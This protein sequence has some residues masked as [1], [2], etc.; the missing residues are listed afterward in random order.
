MR[1]K[2][3]GLALALVGA[4]VATA[5]TVSAEGAT[6][7]GQE[8]TIIVED[9][10]LLTV[11]TDG[12]DVIVG[13]LGP[14]AIDAGAGNDIICGHSGDD[15]LIGGAGND[16]IEGGNDDDDIQGGDGDDTLFGGNGDDILRGANGDDIVLGE[17]GND[18]LEGNAG[19]DTLWPGPGNDS[20][21]DGPG[22][23]AVG[24]GSDA[25]S[26]APDDTSGNDDAPEP[27]IAVPPTEDPISVGA[28]FD[29]TILHVN[30][31][32][33]HLETDSGDL[34]LPGGETRVQF[35]GFPSVVAKIDELAAQ[36]SGEVV[37][38]HAGDAITGTLFFSL[39][40][41]EADAA[42]MNEACFDVFALGN[43]EFDSSDQGLA[44]FL[45]YLNGS[46]SCST[47]TLGANIVPAAGT[48]LAP[49]GDK[50]FEDNVI[51][52]YEGGQ[53]VGYVGI[54]IAG[55]TQNSS[56]PLDTTQ[57]LDEI[58][59]AQA[60]VDLLTA[61]GI[62]KIVLVTHI[63]LA[64]DLDLASQVSGVDVIVGGDS[65]T[66]LGDFGDLGLNTQGEYPQ[67]TTDADGNPVCVVQAWQFSWVVGELNVSF[68]ENGIVSSCEGTP[69]L[70]LADSFQREPSED[71]DRE[72][73]TGEARDEVVAFV[74]ATPELSIVTPDADAEA[75][76]AQFSGQVEVLQQQVIGEATEDLCLERI[77]GQ[78]RSQICD[79]TDTSVYGGDIQQLV[80]DAFLA[81]S[82]E[83]DIAIQNSG[84]IR[85]DIPEGEITI[86]DVL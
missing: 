86:A 67:R 49:E 11:G 78:G 48:P 25:P 71:A 83:A 79:V 32:H 39:F 16:R 6:C 85:I 2:A 75:V 64:N 60:Q 50:I 73:L 76:L 37:K 55:K 20:V 70:L 58:E 21:L 74:E 34:E 81:R 61:A 28:P 46:D 65:H 7:G 8:A 62:D 43:H 38:V 19:D 82:V 47:A 24:Q 36:A 30:D 57:F 54:N 17:A 13:S 42:L 53:R 9:S 52:D 77:P 59:T 56:S 33:S 27:G 51:I 12:D 63:Q 80:T 3:A 69:H 29:L 44:D 15:I 10:G 41:G 35:G 5:P 22:D 40:E 84:G 26:N 31:T 45:G 18:Q 23:D 14:D 66:L 72:E 1:L 68:D 4:L